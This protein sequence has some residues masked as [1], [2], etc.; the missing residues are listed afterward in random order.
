ML[1]SHSS[2]V[3]G[4]SRDADARTIKKAYRKASKTAHPDKGGTEAKMAALN[5]AYEVL[6]NPGT[7]MQ[8]PLLGMEGGGGGEK[9]E[10]ECGLFLARILVLIL[11]LFLISFV[12][13]HPTSFHFRLLLLRP[14]SSVRQWRR[15]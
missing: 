1:F 15:P 14:Q 12:S 11:F 2:Q 4:V 9:G 10:R 8:T 3:L 13:L 7:S 5:E 6:S